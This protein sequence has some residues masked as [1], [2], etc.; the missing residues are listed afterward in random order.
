MMDTQS[1]ATSPAMRR[2]AKELGPAGRARLLRVLE[3]PEKERAESI[4]QLHQRD[5]AWLLEK[6]LIELEDGEWAPRAAVEEL[7]RWA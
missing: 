1:L 5:D 4:G 3:V 6:L 7:G 2:L